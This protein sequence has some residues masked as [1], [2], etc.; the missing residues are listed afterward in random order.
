MNQAVPTGSFQVTL[1][2][3][4]LSPVSDDD[5]LQRLRE[6]FNLT[7]DQARQLLVGPLIVRQALE[8]KF[9]AKVASA[10]RACGMEAL[11]EPMTAIAAAAAPPPEPEPQTRSLAPQLALR[12]LAAQ[13]PIASRLDPARESRIRRA[14][15]FC[16]AIPGTY[17]ALIVLI[18]IG[19]GYSILRSLKA[20][21][22]LGLIGGLYSMLVPGLGGALVLLLLLRPLLSPRRPT[23][24]ELALE[25]G[26]ESEFFRG[27]EALCTVLG[28]PQPKHVL[29]TDEP[30]LRL[31]VLQR[32][33]ATRLHLGLPLVATLSARELT[34]LTAQC[35][36]Q[37]C[38]GLPLMRVIAVQDW[39]ERRAYHSDAWD[40]ALEN[41]QRKAKAGAAQLLG[42]LVAAGFG[43]GRLLM[44]ALHRLSLRVGRDARHIAA[45]EADRR[46]VELVGNRVFRPMLRA[47]RAVEQACDEVR[48]IALMPTPGHTLPEDL[49][50]AIAEQYRAMDQAALAAIDA[51]LDLDRSAALPGQPPWVERVSR[52]ATIPVASSYASNGPARLLLEEY[53]P[54][55]LRL[56]VEW[57]E[58]EGIVRPT[59][60]NGGA[61]SGETLARRAAREMQRETL[62]RYFNG[63]FRPWPLMQPQAPVD[64]DIIALGWQGTIDTLRKRSPELTQDWVVAAEWERRRAPLLLAAG[65]RLKPSQFGLSGCDHLDQEDLWRLLE[66]VRRRDTDAHHRLGSDLKLHAFRIDC[67]IR[68]LQDHHERLQAEFLRTLLQRLQDMEADASMLAEL[69]RAAL[70][71]HTIVA[72]GEH[73]DAEKDLIEVTRLFRQHAHRLLEAGRNVAQTV[74]EGKSVSGHLLARC[75]LAGPERGTDAARYLQDADGMVEAFEDLYLAALGELVTLCERAERASGIRP[76]RRIDPVALGL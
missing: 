22:D 39:L 20:L 59:A 31:E 41:R 30:S 58:R 5:L 17:I 60:R 18:A 11:V 73:R 16:A 37:Q 23:V 10:F 38:G 28:V 66:E 56:S 3:R 8:V 63:Q 55:C 4:R 25:P 40:D 32:G 48:S 49:F 46:T 27:L 52:A 19:W 45:Y 61:L 69:Q 57:Y 6:Q 76:I 62:A 1:T 14:A 42:R 72:D 51:E 36:G 9:A 74:L 2:G 44:V 34:G 50:E 26:R 29:L 70:A 7:T 13:T 68:A 64:P 65:L 53:E 67:A 21:P 33:K 47:L 24:G 12:A 75:P 43:F 54:Y 71:L 15:L 35:L